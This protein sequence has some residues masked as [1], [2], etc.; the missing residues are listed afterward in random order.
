LSLVFSVVESE[1]FW[2]CSSHH[3]VC[4]GMVGNLVPGFQSAHTGSRGWERWEK[5]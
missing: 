2:L 3:L 4:V 1:C 5:F